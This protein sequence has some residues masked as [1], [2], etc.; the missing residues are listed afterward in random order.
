ML[1]TVTIDDHATF[2]RVSDVLLAELQD[3]WSRPIVVKAEQQRDGTYELVCR[4]V[5]AN[6]E[7]STFGGNHHHGVT[8]RYRV[9]R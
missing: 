3:D 5:D 2:V 4:I 7:D 8:G 9:R 6:W 1:R